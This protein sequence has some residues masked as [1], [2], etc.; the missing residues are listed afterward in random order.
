M[1]P[2][3]PEWPYLEM[4]TRL[5]LALAIGLFV[6]LERERRNKASG[7]RT[8]AFT[9]MLGCLGGLLG[10]TYALIILL[11][12]GILITFLNVQ[13]LQANAGT[14]LT[15]SVALVLIA[16]T[17]ILCGIGQ[18]FTPVAVAVATT[19]LLA[20][21][22]PLSSFS[23]LVNETE[24]RSAILLGILAFIIYPALPEEPID[25]WGIV[26]AQATFVTVLLIAVI[27]FVNY[28][29]WKIYGD[30]GIALTGFLGGLVN[31][32]AAVSELSS[33]VKESD[34]QLIDVGHRGILLAV[35]A[36][37][38]RNSCIL[39][40][41]APQAFLHAVFAQAAMLLSSAVLIVLDRKPKQAETNTPLLHIQSPFSLMAAL[42]FGAL[43]LVLQIISAIAQRNLGDLGLYG[44]TVLGSIVSSSSTVAAT[45]S[46]A[47]QGTVPAAT[48]GLGTTIATLTSTVVTL[49]MI[50]RAQVPEL[51]K[52]FAWA[53]LVIMIAGVVGVTLQ[54][55][56]GPRLFVSS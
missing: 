38:L 53:T 10:E 36:M 32:M 12:L 2:Q 23:K 34:G 37:I 41:L 43:F 51:N 52:R 13:S 19:A 9:A 28:I 17:G 4:L 26:S 20:W 7:V 35:S 40:I 21:K 1:P 6:G 30:R 46:L 31:S 39:A 48:A 50:M 25:P 29:L 14:E 22:E 55:L 27:S 24:I 16:I 54:L 45:A 18:T 11:L 56:L 42:R 5:G 15:T 44:S 49:P 33:R 47:S 3:S 8:F